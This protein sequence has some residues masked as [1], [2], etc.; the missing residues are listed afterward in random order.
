MAGPGTQGGKGIH[1][2]GGDSLA[3]VIEVP[4]SEE[5][6]SETPEAEGGSADAPDGQT[7]GTENMNE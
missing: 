5:P 3:S 1:L 6:E 7:S 2:R 4:K